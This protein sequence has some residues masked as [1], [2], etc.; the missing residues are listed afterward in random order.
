[1]AKSPCP[2]LEVRRWVES[3]GLKIQTNAQYNPSNRRN[4]S[5]GQKM[6]ITFGSIF[7]TILWISL[8]KH[9]FS[10]P[11][12]LFFEITRI[13]WNLDRLFSWKWTSKMAEFLSA[14]YSSEIE[15]YIIPIRT[16]FRHLKTFKC[17]RFCLNYHWVFENYML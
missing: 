5:P 10:F 7:N 1:M 15:H 17:N 12:D 2:C 4:Y 8:S 3:H 16:L 13:W 9:C 6:R 11:K 14:E